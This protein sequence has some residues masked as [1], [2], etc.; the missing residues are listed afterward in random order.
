MLILIRRCGFFIRNNSDLKPYGFS[1][2]KKKLTMQPTCWT[3]TR[4]TGIESPGWSLYTDGGSKR[5]NHMWSCR[6]GTPFTV[7]GAP[8]CCNNTAEL[9]GFAEDIFL[10][11]F[12][13]S[14]RCSPTPNAARVTLVAVHAEKNI[15]LDRTSYI[16]F[17]WKCK[18][19]ISAHLFYGHAG[20]TGNECVDAAAV[21]G[22]RGF[23]SEKRAC[24]LA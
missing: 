6:V 7:F 10:V 17:R 5:I 24:F 19:H 2:S 9:S 16:L 3:T 14:S 15:S 12:L 18:F 23:V 20:K 4:L 8:T 1:N 11:G 21:L 22:M 13:F